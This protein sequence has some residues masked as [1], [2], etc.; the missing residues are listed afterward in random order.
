MWRN[1]H[2]SVGYFFIVGI[3]VA[4]FS[5]FIR[6]VAQLHWETLSWQPIAMGILIGC[7][8][9]GLGRLDYL[10]KKKYPIS[11]EGFREVL[12]VLLILSVFF[13]LTVAAA[14]WPLINP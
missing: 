8:L 14:L 4:A 7:F 2:P 9:L 3:F 12:M 6:K 10:L 11:G 13:L 1:Y 5:T